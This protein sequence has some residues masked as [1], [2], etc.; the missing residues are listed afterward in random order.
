MVAI[1]VLVAAAAVPARADTIYDNG[2][3]D[4]N[5]QA[6]AINFGNSVSDSFFLSQSGFFVTGATIGLWAFPGDIPRT[7]D[8]SLGTSFF[9]SDVASGTSSLTRKFDFTNSFGHDVYTS[10][11]S[12]GTLNFSFQQGPYYLTLQNATTRFD[13]PIYWDQNNGPSQAMDSSLGPVPSETF[14]ILG[15]FEGGGPAEPASFLLLGSGLLG[16]VG[17]IRRRMKA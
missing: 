7:V 17:A 3:L 4:G 11:L 16:L 10:T 8:W 15:T 1:A 5:T 12:F 2:P 6:Y 13:N 9:A 14:Q